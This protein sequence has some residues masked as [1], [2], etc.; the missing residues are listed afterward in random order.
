MIIMVTKR[1]ETVKEDNNMG[2]KGGND[3]IPTS[4]KEIVAPKKVA[5]PE[6][7]EV[8]Q[9]KEKSKVDATET[10]KDKS[11]AGT[12]KKKAKPEKMSRKMIVKKSEETIE[13]RTKALHKKSLPVFRGRFGKRS[14]R[15]KANKKWAKWRFPRG[16]DVNHELSEGFNPRGGYRTPREIR[17]V[18]PSGYMEVI[19]KNSEELQRIPENHAARVVSGMGR[20]KKL[21]L[22]DK[23]IE[24]GIK[25][26]NP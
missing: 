5:T 26:L 4:K 24:L 14:I 10:K 13:L 17:G 23:A 6:K 18:H 3:R 12:V 22:V 20:K 9:P 16:L 19:V 2:T 11:K 15:K 1:K 7:K 25:V 21:A 8:M